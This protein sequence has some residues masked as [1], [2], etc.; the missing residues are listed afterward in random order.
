[1]TAL[2]NVAVASAH[3]AECVDERCACYA[4]VA[5][6]TP[7]PFVV[8]VMYD[9]ARDS[10]IIPNSD[11]VAH[12]IKFVSYGETNGKPTRSRE[13]PI[14]DFVKGFYLFARARACE[15][16]LRKFLF[17]LGHRYSELGPRSRK[18][19]IHI[20][21]KDFHIFTV[22]EMDASRNRLVSRFYY[23]PILRPL[24]NNFYGT[25]L[26]LFARQTQGTENGAERDTIELAIKE[27]SSPG[28]SAAQ[29]AYVTQ[30]GA[31]FNFAN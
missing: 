24:A 2:L 31:G 14:K 10:Y 28:Y 3:V 8:D 16:C 7:L 4:G 25:K 5:P 17:I 11:H 22:R 23:A 15:F 12:V 21:A 26:I 9:G 20:R 13:D 1:M 6:R 30:L 19:C 29:R 18:I 27:S